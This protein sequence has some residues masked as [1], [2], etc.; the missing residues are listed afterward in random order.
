MLVHEFWQI[1]LIIHELHQVLLHD[2]VLI[3]GSLK[4]GL[5]TNPIP[6]YTFVV[7][8]LINALTM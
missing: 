7:N 5:L 2:S 6:T 8:D 4:T 1:F 3:G